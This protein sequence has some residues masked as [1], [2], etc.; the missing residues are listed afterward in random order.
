MRSS[1]QHSTPTD[2]AY[3]GL[4]LAFRI[5]NEELFEGSLPQCL[6]TLQR[7]KASCGYYSADR[8][9]N[10]S[11]QTVDEIAL[12]P[13]YFG[14]VPLMETMQTLTHEQVHL[15][16]RHF[17]KPGRGRYHNAEWADKMQSIGL[18]PSSTGKPG[19]AITGDHMADYPIPGGLFEKVFLEHFSTPEFT[20]PWYDRYPPPQAVAIATQIL[21]LKPKPYAAQISSAGALANDSEAP[22]PACSS[23]A[24]MDG[25]PVL[26]PS[27][28]LP[29]L[30]G[31][32]SK[33]KY[34]C[35]CGV[36]V[37]GK[38]GLRI[39]CEN[40]QESFIVVE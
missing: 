28:Q 26:M 20:I 38:P 6:I 39:R 22:L 18:M 8:F 13:A 35:S 7:E 29:S 19:G 15:W 3:G 14:I 4:Q 33:T 12:N 37:W 1:S 30:S 31:A 17:G 5:L 16:Q 2:E 24:G 36:N 25:P 23:A 34:S 40:C 32:R 27:V 21:A 11:G 10:R 9:G